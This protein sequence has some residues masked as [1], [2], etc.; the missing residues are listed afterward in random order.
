MARNPT[1]QNASQ[2]KRNER[3]GRETTKV[4]SMTD[5]GHTIEKMDEGRRGPAIKGKRRAKRLPFLVVLVIA[6]LLSVPLASIVAVST[7]DKAYAGDIY[8]SPTGSS[9]YDGAGNCMPEDIFVHGNGNIGYCYDHGLIFSY[10]WYNYFS[11]SFWADSNV[12]KMMAQAYPYS[13]MGLDPYGA[14][15]ATQIA[16][17]AVNSGLDTGALWAEDDWGW[18]IIAAAKHLEWVY[19]YGPPIVAASFSGA[20]GD[21]EGWS[22]DDNNMMFG[23]FLASTNIPTTWLTEKTLY[24]TDGEYYFCDRWG[25]WIDPGMN[26]EFYVK[27][28]KDSLLR[29]SSGNVSM[30]NIVQGTTPAIS[31]WC[32]EYWNQRVVECAVDPV[33]S[34]ST[35]RL[36]W[37]VVKYH[38]VG[39][40]PDSASISYPGK[41]SKDRLIDP[42]GFAVGYNQEYAPESNALT[43]ASHSYQGKDGYTWVFSGWYTDAA[44]TQ[45]F[46]GGWLPNFCQSNRTL[47]LYGQWTKGRLVKSTS[48]TAPVE[49][50]GEIPYTLS[51]KN[52]GNIPIN[53]LVV[54]PAPWNTSLIASSVQSPIITKN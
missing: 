31:V 39:E 22:S 54:D 20:Y 1:K 13:T 16:I 8:M 19:Y 51:F 52:E 25:N 45:R 35:S 41:Y 12:H 6:A 11:D 4:D 49:V 14:R 7:P 30:T 44:C 37:G 46:T 15:V 40:Q 21:T 9:V 38:V 53:L 48:Q 32:G 34:W 29:T 33:N 36:N 17:W 28:A 10:G 18:S 43:S 47:D 2:P 23:P 5:Q 3:S 50:D 26:Q 42:R 24:G 27:V